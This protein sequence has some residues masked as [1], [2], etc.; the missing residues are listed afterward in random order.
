[1][2][3]AYNSSG[4]QPVFDQDGG[5]VGTVVFDEGERLATDGLFC[6]HIS[7]LRDEYRDWEAQADGEQSLGVSRTPILAYA[8]V[9]SRVEGSQNVF[10]RVGLAE[11]GYDWIMAGTEE[12]VSFV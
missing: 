6:A 12:E 2:L 11:V 4:A 5:V 8:L 10:A 7:T 1:M 3:L 9:V